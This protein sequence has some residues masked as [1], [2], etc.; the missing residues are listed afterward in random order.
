MKI[1]MSHT[2]PKALLQKYV[3]LFLLFLLL[4]S[5]CASSSIIQSPKINTAKSLQEKIDNLLADSVLVH[6]VASVK[7]VS[8]MNG[9]ILYDRNS[10]LL[11][12]PASNQK[13]FTSAAALM[14]LGPAFEF[15]TSVVC[16]SGAF[17]PGVIQGDLY[18]TGRGDPDLTINDLFTLT[19][20]LSKDSLHVITGNIICDDS[21]FDDVR[22]GQGWMWDDEPSALW[23][24]FTA[25]TLNDNAVV[26]T[27]SPGKYIGDSARIVIEPHNNFVEI[28]NTSVTVKRRAEIDSLELSSLK[29]N[30]RWQQHENVYTVDG[31]IGMDEKPHQ[32][33]MNILNP[34]ILAGHVF[35]GLLKQAG[36]EVQGEVKRGKSP[37]RRQLLAEYRR[38]LLPVLVNLNKKSDNLSAELLLKTIGAEALGEPG[39]SEKGIRTIRE[40][41]SLIDV[42]TLAIRIADGSGVS[43]YNLAT[44][45]AVI[46]LLR[47][48]WQNH[49]VRHEFITTLPI[50]GV[51]GTLKYRMRGT[52]SERVLR[53]KTGSL[54]G[55][56]TLSGYTVTADGEDIVFSIMLQ[57]FL[58][59]NSA[60]RKIQDRICTEL[61]SFHR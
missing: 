44:P 13:L 8:L 23:S 19:Q 1:S 55:V 31:M 38:P 37:V 42:D 9:D 35:K 3:S 7:V 21:Y 40:F 48:M 29:I 50:A 22:W 32:R 45:N 47:A 14:T 12:H 24:R 52:R 41:L 46:K 17:E 54:S 57:H 34:E 60:V 25:L 4:I 61:N 39:S 11:F 10:N 20:K 58:A 43:R 5:G 33:K 27:A 16:D 30:R 26:V 6:S 28:A 18:L 15:I 49:E 53:A 56:S 59:P 51:D 36:I 2:S